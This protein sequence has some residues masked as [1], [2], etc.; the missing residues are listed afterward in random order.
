MERSW[1]HQDGLGKGG[2]QTG[3]R[4]GEIHS[5]HCPASHHFLSGRPTAVTFEWLSFPTLVPL[6]PFLHLAPTPP[7]L[8]FALSL[9]VA[10]ICNVSNNHSGW[11]CC[12]GSCEESEWAV[13]EEF[14]TKISWFSDY[15]GKVK[16]LSSPKIAPRNR[17]PTHPLS[18]FFFFLHSNPNEIVSKIKGMSFTSCLHCKGL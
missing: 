9:Q 6:P 15:S 10:P 17:L 4:A 2:E 7:G 5:S 8:G 16:Y 13:I 3:A 14:I 18:T 1:N 12:S 11:W